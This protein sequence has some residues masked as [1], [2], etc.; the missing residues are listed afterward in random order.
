MNHILKRIDDLERLLV[1][2]RELVAHRVLFGSP[3]ASPAFLA[4]LESAEREMIR[5]QADNDELRHE[6]TRR[7]SREK[8]HLRMVGK[9]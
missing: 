6:L 7:D 5:L 3:E 8:R 2:E 1:I 9:D 4:R